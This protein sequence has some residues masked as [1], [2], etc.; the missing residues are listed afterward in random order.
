[1]EE[2]GANNYPTLQS[3]GRKIFSS[4]FPIALNACGVSLLATILVEK[5]G[6]AHFLTNGAN[7][8]QRAQ[9]FYFAFKFFQHADF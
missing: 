9:H 2:Q 7:F 5:V 8:R 4:T 3:A 6:G 1:V